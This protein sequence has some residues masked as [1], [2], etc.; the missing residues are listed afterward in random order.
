M[1]RLRRPAFPGSLHRIP[2]VGGA[3]AAGP[4]S[5]LPI[6]PLNR[7][8]KPF[9]WDLSRREQLGRLVVPT[10]P[11]P[12]PA[13]LANIRLCSA[14]ILARAGDSTLAFI[15]R[16]PE[17]LFDYLSG[18]LGPTEWRDRA[19]LVNLSIARIDERGGRPGQRELDLVREQLRQAGLDPT[20]LLRHPRPVALLDLVSSGRTLGNLVTLL[21]AWAESMGTAPEAVYRRIRV[22][23]ITVQG[24]NSP[25]AWRWQQQVKWAGL[26]RPTALKGCFH[27][28]RL[29][30]LSR[31]LSGQDG[32]FESF[33]ALGYAGTTR[34]I[35][36][37][38]SS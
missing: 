33:L 3:L 17:S 26:F 18:I 9:R 16:S 7:V 22:V 28:I 5:R 4:S 35:P 29:L 21:G 12:D 24:K 25:N 20:D 13:L 32:A 2:P 27:P 6:S 1:G 31:R 30:G 19:S 11:R 37:P 23:G 38:V 8:P 10:P 15:G 14:R 36:G 34:S